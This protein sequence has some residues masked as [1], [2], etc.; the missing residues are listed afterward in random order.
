[1]D[2]IDRAIID[3]LHWDGRMSNQ[4]LAER[5]GLT[6]APCLRRVRRLEADGVITGYGAMLDPAALGRGFEVIVYADL[7]AK[8]LA[9]V[10]AFEARLAGMP[11]VLELRRM[12]GIPDYFIRVGV[13]DLGAYERWLTARLMGDPAISRVDSRLTMK[14]LKAVR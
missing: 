3:L 1:M 4:E 2:S 10:E 13:A 8:D 7:V 5:V 9:T 14:V 12:F 11:E 6:P